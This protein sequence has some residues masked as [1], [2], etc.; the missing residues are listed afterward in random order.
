MTRAPSF[1]IRHAWLWLLPGSVLVAMLLLEGALRLVPSLLPADAQQRLLWS[2]QTPIKSIG[3]PH[4]GFTYPPYFRAEIDSPDF[5]FSIESDE[6]GFRN[7]S[8]WPATA[9]VVIVG[10]S[11]A[12]GYGVAQQ[13]AWPTLLGD[14]L[15]GVRV[16]SLGMPGAVPQQ[17]ARYFERFGVTLR[18]KVLIFTI[19]AGNDVVEAETFERWVAAGSPGNYDVWRFFEGAVPPERTPLF[20]SSYLAQT[21]R[22]VRKTLSYGFSSTDV[23]LPNGGRIRLAPNLYGDALRRGHPGDPGFDAVIRATLEARDLAR[24]IDCQFVVLFV[25]TKELVYLPLQGVKFPG[26]IGPL[27]D[28]LGRQPGIVILDA[29]DPLRGHAARGEKLYFE[30]DGHPDEFGNRVLADY[31]AQ[32]LRTNARALGIE[33]GTQADIQSDRA[34]AR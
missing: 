31:L 13:K 19:F 4:L 15:P 23:T 29:L 28:A 20:D 25:P 12:Y 30:I 16:I 32:Y 14:A 8:P 3:D 7:H 27:K 26:I 18:P 24:S 10:D 21:L 9:E 2:N 22:S 6:H 11:M 17:Y 5:R 1:L 33:A 34:R